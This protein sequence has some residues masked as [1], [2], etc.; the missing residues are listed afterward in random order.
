[1]GA[2]HTGAVTRRLAVGGSAIIGG[3]ERKES[4][5]GRKGREQGRLMGGAGDAVRE[6]R[7]KRVQAW[8]LTVKAE[9]GHGT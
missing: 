4:A 9:A 8:V 5:W 3:E 7:E 2:C 1:M 6:R